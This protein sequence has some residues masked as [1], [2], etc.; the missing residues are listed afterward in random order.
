MGNNTS[1]LHALAYDLDLSEDYF[2]ELFRRELIEKIAKVEL[3]RIDDDIEDYLDYRDY[4]K[5]YIICGNK[6]LADMTLREL[7]THCWKQ[8]IKENILYNQE[9]F[10]V[11]CD[12]FILPLLKKHLT[13]I[14][15]TKL[16][17]KINE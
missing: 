12:D 13:P 1:I 17:K 9:E 8:L 6:G 7:F 3:K 15:F 2:S 16:V 4:L 10:V 14:E 5:T 11:Y